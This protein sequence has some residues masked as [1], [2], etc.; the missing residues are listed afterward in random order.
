M[1]EGRISG[2]RMRTGMIVPAKAVI[3]ATGTYLRGLILSGELRYSSGPHGAMPSLLLSESLEKIGVS[4]RR[5]KPVPP[6]ACIAIRSIIRIW[7]CNA[8]MKNSFR[9]LL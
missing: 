7:K 4:L 3:L 1:E 5:F 2:V 8:A 9:F 6:P